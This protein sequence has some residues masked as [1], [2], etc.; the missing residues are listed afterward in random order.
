LLP[1][2]GLTAQHGESE[3]KALDL[4]AWDSCPKSVQRRSMVARMRAGLKRVNS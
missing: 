4:R 3:E 1:V 2:L